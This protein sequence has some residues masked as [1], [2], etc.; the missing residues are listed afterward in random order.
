MA[1]V[2]C[3]TLSIEQIAEIIYLYTVEGVSTQKMTKYYG[4]DQPLI[5]GIQQGGYLDVLR[6]FGFNPLV[7]NMSVDRD[8]KITHKL[9]QHLGI[10]DKGY[11][12]KIEGAKV[13][14]YEVDRELILEYLESDYASDEP[15]SFENYL[16]DKYREEIEEEKEEAERLRKKREAEE[17]EKRRQAELERERAER[18]RIARMKTEEYQALCRQGEAL[19]KTDPEQAISKYSRACKIF[20]ETNLKRDIAAEMIDRIRE[21]QIKEKEARLRAQ[22]NSEYE[23]G[24][25][26]Y[27]SGS[28]K[29]A[30][31]HFLNARKCGCADPDISIYIARSIKRFSDKAGG[32][33]AEDAKMLIAEMYKYIRYLENNRGVIYTDYYTMLAE[34]YSVTGQ[35]NEQCDALF[36]AGDIFYDN[37]KYDQALKLYEKAYSETKMW[38]VKSNNA[39][40]RFG[41][42]VMQCRDLKNYE[43][44]SSA[45]SWFMTAANNNIAVNESVHNLVVLC[46]DDDESIISLGGSFTNAFDSE[47]LLKRLFKAQTN[48][49][50]YAEA[51][52]TA[53]KFF[54]SF[55]SGLPVIP[56]AL[57]YAA[58]GS[59]NNL[60]FDICRACDI[61]F[62]E[63]DK[64]FEKND[65]EKADKY[66]T[67]GY[68]ETG[69]WSHKSKDAPYRMAF[70]RMK[71]GNSPEDNAYA[72]RWFRACT[73]LLIR[74]DE[75]NKYLKELNG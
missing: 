41:Y 19:I 46:G 67:M 36:M 72:A 38:S 7:N 53:D 48:K 54:N 75:A 12:S 25:A 27:N 63:G 31:M 68:E 11:V 70:A 5:E 66:Y 4:D 13:R 33:T 52:Y 74:M 26:D 8:G 50:L 56:C 6:Q 58:R 39:P 34:A 22:A 44:K 73:D 45:I 57:S 69:L 15:F 3:S 29:S 64:A 40:F 20:R 14:K 55:K 37:E 16:D 49:G 9:Q 10:F 51:A 59:K 1:D 42:A 71:T 17:A 62:S 65:F 24:V 43:V 23:K 60:L 28:Y 30:E 2:D 18:E 35:K 21:Q 47:F 32:M 61:F